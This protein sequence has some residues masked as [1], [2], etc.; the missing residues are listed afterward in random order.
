MLK[1][2]LSVILML[3]L[4]VGCSEEL[5]RQNP[6][7]KPPDNNITL[8]EDGPDVPPGFPPI[9]FPADNPYSKVKAELGRKLYYERLLSKDSTIAS[10]SH[11]FKQQNGFT[12]N[13]PVSLG[14]NQIP[15]FRNTM[16]HANVAYRDTNMI[17]WDGR[18]KRVE[19][20]ALRSIFL[21]MVL[22]A[23]TNEIQKRLE[24][25]PEY[26]E[27]FRKAFGINAKPQAYLIAKAIATFVR[28]LVSGNSRYDKYIRGDS[29]ALNAS[30]KRGMD[31]FNSERTRCSVCH[32][33]IF[34]TDMKFHNTGIVSH[35]FDLGRYVIT[36]KAEDWGR[37][38]TPSLRNVEL[39]APYMHNGELF[40]L[41]EILHH[42]NNGGKA[43]ITKDTLMRPLNLT[44]T[45]IA[46]LIAF[47][48]SLT[49]YEFINNKKFSKPD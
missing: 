20:P 7:N 21:P 39:S 35:Y 18:G 41:E 4:A 5:V 3:V 17:F 27:L 9:P 47:L 1:Y 19:S 13:V 32:S 46:D 31:L 8:P 22:G 40:T 29:Y 36:G 37:F 6:V 23:D 49:D 25:H 26:P 11:C 16:S 33:G 14:F 42:Y 45:D 30:E 28:T 2:I 38:L 48:K 44:S 43:F 10:C 24:N 15:E 34:F 12:D